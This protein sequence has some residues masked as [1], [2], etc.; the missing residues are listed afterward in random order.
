M[1]DTTPTPSFSVAY[2]RGY[3]PEYWV[4]NN[5]NRGNGT[6][7]AYRTR[8]QAERHAALRMA[9]VPRETA[10]HAVANSLEIVRTGDL[11]FVDAF[12][13]GLLPAKVLKIERVPVPNAPNDAYTQWQVT[14][15]LTA[16]RP[17]YKRGEVLVK[18]GTSQVESIVPRKTVRIVDGKYRIRSGAFVAG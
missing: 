1:D 15:R 11:V 6:D 13:S 7:G 16:A 9:G 17:G 18:T 12:R 14:V 8:E 10:M 4:H 3:R 2:M 5:N